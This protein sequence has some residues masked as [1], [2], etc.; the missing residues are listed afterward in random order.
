M[1]MQVGVVILTR[2]LLSI[3]CVVAAVYCPAGF[4]IGSDGESCEGCPQDTY[5]PAK[6][7]YSNACTPCPTERPH[8]LSANST[9]ESDCRIGLC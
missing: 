8:T 5:K 9:A 3:L 6:D 1:F 2:L 7:Y 4:H